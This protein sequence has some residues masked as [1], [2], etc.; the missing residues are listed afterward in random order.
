ME[1]SLEGIKSIGFSLLDYSFE[2]D[3]EPG[4]AWIEQIIQY[5]LRNSFPPGKL[6]NVNIPKLPAES[7]LGVR[8]CRQANARWVEEFLEG[9]DPNNQPYYWLSGKFENQDSGEDTD[10]WALEN[11]YI[12]VVPSM[13]DLTDYQALDGMQTLETLNA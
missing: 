9:R 4:K 7:I 12:S 2:A 8:I 11:G 13:H 6:L 5:S 3:F 1:A 10:V